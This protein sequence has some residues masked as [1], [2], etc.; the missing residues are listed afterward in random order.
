MDTYKN[1]QFFTFLDLTS[2]FSAGTGHWVK[3]GNAPINIHMAF[4]TPLKE[5]LVLLVIAEY[6]KIVTVDQNGNVS[7]RDAPLH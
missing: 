1:G 6:E 2:D 3:T 4:K 5:N 7:S